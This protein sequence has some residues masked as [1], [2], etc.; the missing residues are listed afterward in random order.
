MKAEN[1]TIIVTGG[2]S[3]MGRELVLNLL[4]KGAK[5]AAI[6]INE[7][8]LQETAALAGDRNVNLSLFVTDITNRA[9]VEGLNGMV[10]PFYQLN[11]FTCFHFGHSCCQW[12]LVLSILNC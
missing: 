5:V 8:T 2:G 10:I 4:A 11:P 1:K 9:G 6:D 12:I 3:G 7:K